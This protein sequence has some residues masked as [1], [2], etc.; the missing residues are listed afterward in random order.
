MSKEARAL[1]GCQN[2]SC[3]EQMSFTLDMVRMYN[4]HPICDMCYDEEMFANDNED[5]RAWDS[6]PKVTLANLRE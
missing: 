1:V 4:G 3:A 6:L 2:E 5:E